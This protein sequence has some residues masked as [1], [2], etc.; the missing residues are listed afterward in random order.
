MTRRTSVLFF[1]IV[2]SL[3]FVFQAFGEPGSSGVKVIKA[4]ILGDNHTKT[5]VPLDDL[6][7]WDVFCR[8]D[9]G[10]V[11]IAIVV[12][13]TGSMSGEIHDVQVNLNDFTDL[14][15]ATGYDV[16]YALLTYGDG[17]TFPH[18]MIFTP[19]GAT[20]Q[21]WVD[22][23]RASGGG[24]Y[25]ETSIDGISDAINFLPWRPG[26]LHVILMITDATF[27]ELGDGSG[28]SDVDP[29]VL[30]DLIVSSGVVVY[31]VTPDSTA[32]LAYAYNY[33]SGYCDTSGGGWFELG[34]SFSVIFSDLVELFGTFNLVSVTVANVDGY[35]DY[36]SAEITPV[37]CMSLLFGENPQTQYDI[38]PAEF[39]NFQWRVEV[40]EDCEYPMDCFVLRFYNDD[41]EDTTLGCWSF[42]ENC[43]SIPPTADIITP[44][45]GVYTACE[46]QYISMRVSSIV[47]INLSSIRVVINGD[48]YNFP[49][50]LDFADDILTFTP[51]VPWENGDT[52]LVQL[53]R[54]DD[55]YGIRLDEPLS[56][57]FYTDLEPPIYYDEYPPDGVLIGSSPDEVAISLT[58]EI[59]GLD[60]STI[61]LELGGYTF[62]ITSPEVTWDG[63]RFTLD[64]EAAGIYFATGDT[65]CPVLSGA[66]DTPDLCDPNVME[67]YSWCF[68][69]DRLHVWFE[70]TAGHIEDEILIPVYAQDP[71]RFSMSS[72]DMDICY[73]ENI[74]EVLGIETA[75]SLT[76]PWGSIVFSD[77]GMGMLSLS[78]SGAPLTTDT[79]VL[80]YIHVRILST[81]YQGG[82][83]PLNFCS[84]SLDE[85]EIEYY[86]DNA[87]LIVRWEP[88]QWLAEIRVVGD[89]DVQD[90]TLS[91]GAN[92]Y[93]SDGYNPGLDIIALP[94][95]NRVNA[96]FPLSDPLY[97]YITKLDRDI[98]AHEPYPICWTI[99]TEES[100]TLYWDP[101]VFPEGQ[102]IMNGY[103]NM[104]QQ[105]SY[106]F[107][108]F[109]EIEIC[110]RRIESEA[111]DISLC[112]N[113]NLISF[114]VIPVSPN[115]M[116]YLPSMI[117]VPYWYNPLTN[118][119]VPVDIIESGKAYWIYSSQDTSYTVAG[120][121]VDQ[122]MGVLYEGWNMI[123]SCTS[124]LGIS[125]P[126]GR[127][128]GDLYD[129]DCYVYTYGMASDIF[130]W[131]GYW[132]LVGTEVC[133]L[134]ASTDAGD[135]E[136]LKI[137][138]SNDHVNWA[139]MYEIYGN[140]PP[141]PPGYAPMN[142]PALPRTTEIDQNYPNPFNAETRISFSVHV[143]SEVEITVYDLMGKEVRALTDDT[144]QP[145]YYNVMWDGTD[146][147]G[148]GISSG[149]YFY[150]YRIGSEQGTGRMILLR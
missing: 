9:T 76:E 89:A 13:T 142:S 43:E 5:M 100:G 114:P 33:Y 121:P 32:L 56:W 128:I 52:I 29:D 59:T 131:G 148:A 141:Y 88:V 81:A 132:V 74:F 55:L 14:L 2:L 16:Q 34:I 112:G 6:I 134:I 58:D 66:A 57:E 149:I 90:R 130:P 53:V 143:E 91:F 136:F 61:N 67:E 101:D 70:D 79:D 122:Y 147:D 84:V 10:A 37:Y 47:G 92:R 103:I 98:R 35:M 127:I 27:H 77:D 44:M 80:F 146:E 94:P 113:W 41:F 129:W 60:P 24:D 106:R 139:E 19:D 120:T 63:E 93:G 115:F 85:G 110:F 118:S 123:G 54:A 28:Y 23:L 137:A 40:G 42:G 108:A 78:G 1:I 3:I 97:G 138:A 17:V 99:Y 95:I 125:D 72:L 126:F 117:S 107:D 119:Y 46:D 26:A 39:V 109:E 133:T 7:E 83:S 12:D 124:T 116:D 69:V 105:I 51:S 36:L 4:E 65:I 31:N 104:R 21:T 87:I 86:T 18:G 22:H 140:Q 50:H 144:Y 30:M 8:M 64:V 150:R 68:L 20:F 145:G 15:I 62:D 82:Y 11:D 96:Y 102:F 75:G 25:P 38:E 45:P 73:N 135:A 111:G 48:I 49:D 71:E